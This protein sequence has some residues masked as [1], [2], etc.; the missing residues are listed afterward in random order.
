MD[1]RPWRRRGD[2][3]YIGSDDWIGSVVV[4]VGVTLLIVVIAVALFF[5][6]S[7]VVKKDKAEQAARKPIPPAAAVSPAVTPAPSQN[8]ISVNIGAPS[9]T[10]MEIYVGEAKIAVSK[11]AT[12]RKA[13]RRRAKAAK[14]P[15][16]RPARDAKKAAIAKIA[17]EKRIAAT[18]PPA[19]LFKIRLDVVVGANKLTGRSRDIG[20]VIRKGLT[21]GSIK[22]APDT[23]RFDVEVSRGAD[24]FAGKTIYVNGKKIVLSGAFA[25]DAHFEV[26]SKGGEATIA[27]DP[28]F[29]DSATALV[30]K[31]REVIMVSPPDGLPLVVDPGVL[32]AEINDGIQ[33]A[34][35]YFV[36][37]SKQQDSVGNADMIPYQH[38]AP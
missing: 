34:R 8:G 17:A 15:Y 4:S 10:P 28:N 6:L 11:S 25:A 30:V 26:V 21:D 1:K 32:Q 20:S 3:R 38:P 16:H 9:G 22:P 12:I 35:I 13:S 2:V 27:F 29:I 14:K 37:Y 5:A 31:S 33:E 19:G 36:A 23:V 24:R 7:F 18:M